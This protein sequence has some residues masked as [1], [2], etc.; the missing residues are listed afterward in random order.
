MLQSLRSRPARNASARARSAFGSARS[1]L[2]SRRGARPMATLSGR[3]VEALATSL[4]APRNHAT[5]GSLVLSEIHPSAVAINSF[6]TGISWRFV[7]RNDAEHHSCAGNRL[8]KKPRQ[9]IAERT[10]RDDHHPATGRR[11][12]QGIDQTDSGNQPGYG[13]RHR[14]RRGPFHQQPDGSR[15]SRQQQ[16][17]GSNGGPAV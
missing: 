17:E 6:S 12:R 16:N 10:E 15:V 13:Q 14:A 4:M 1:A 5:P 2:P 7:I 9:R 3:S 11:N 8:L